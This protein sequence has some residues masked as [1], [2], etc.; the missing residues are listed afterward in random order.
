LIQVYWSVRQ[1]VTDIFREEGVKGYYRGIVTSL[2]Q[3]APY[4]G[5]LFGT[6]EASRA[7]LT[8]S[9]LL[10]SRTSDF[11]AGG[12]AGIVSKCAVFPLDTV[13]KRLQVQG[14]TR[15]KYIHKDIPVY[16]QGILQCVKDIMQ[17]EGMRGLY[18][19]LGIALLKSG[20]SAAVTL[21]V[22]DGS[23]RIWEWMNHR[24][25]KGGTWHD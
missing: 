20:P 5:L 6:Y 19:G 2:L 8:T 7:S 1:S 10:S 9:S 3:I 13:R 24:P 17:K 14:P 22:F 16:S 25:G 4:M 23:L 18:K 11:L 12:I 21:W 15:E